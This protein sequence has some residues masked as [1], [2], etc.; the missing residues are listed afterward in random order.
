[1]TLSQL[2]Y[3][4]TACDFEN[5]SKASQKLNVAQ[6]SIS[7]AIKAL[8]KE[9][10]TQLIIRQKIGFTLTDAGEKLLELASGLLEHAE[11]VN[12]QMQDFKS[13]H[14][15]INIGI[16]PMAGAILLPTVLSKLK[17]KHKEINISLWEGGKHDIL[18]RLNDN[19]LDIAFIPNDNST[20]LKDYN[21]INVIRLEDVCCVAENHPLSKKN[22]VTINDLEHEAI[23]LF[24][25]SFYHFD[26]IQLLFNEANIKPNI[27]HKTSQLSTMQQ[28]IKSNLATGFLFKEIAEQTSGIKS[29]PV[30]PPIFTEIT[31][32]WSKSKLLNEDMKNFINLFKA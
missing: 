3:F 1:M 7:L 27:I 29:I 9:F 25:D 5:I 15:T 20:T 12:N 11:A 31:L 30:N 22:A 21:Y 24:S 32:V 10:S 2:L 4:K 18:K 28:F 13:I 8:E 19:Q 17:E 23:V 6:P 14:R 16:P 26:K